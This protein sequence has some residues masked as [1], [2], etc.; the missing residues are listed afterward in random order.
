MFSTSGSIERCVILC[1]ARQ[2]SHTESRT[3]WSEKPEVDKCETSDEVYMR[4]FNDCFN[5][6]QPTLSRSHLFNST[7]GC[8]KM[9]PYTSHMP[10]GCIQNSSKRWYTRNYLTATLILLTL[11]P[12]IMLL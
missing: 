12:I 3:W 10:S 5:T 6:F 11:Y 7:N 4:G 2:S 8:V 9:S 1:V